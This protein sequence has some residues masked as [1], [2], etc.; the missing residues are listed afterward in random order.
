MARLTKRVQVLLDPFQYQRLDEI[1]R[2]HNRSVGAL[3]REAIDRVYLQTD[4]AERLGA[5]RALAA[6]QL[7]VAGWEQMEQESVEKITRGCDAK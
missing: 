2:Q 1:A 7:P 3:I 4:M 6:M 5:V